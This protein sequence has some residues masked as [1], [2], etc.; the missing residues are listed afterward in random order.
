[1]KGVPARILMSRFSTTRP[2]NV[3]VLLSCVSEILVSPTIDNSDDPS[4]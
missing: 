3:N 2:L 1:M 4:A